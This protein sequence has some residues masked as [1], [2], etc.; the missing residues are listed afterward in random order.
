MEKHV[1]NYMKAFGYD[2]SSFI[3]CELCGAKATDI[4]HVQPRSKFGSKRK[5]EQDELENLIALCRICHEF[6]HSGKRNFKMR[7]VE[8]V[9]NRRNY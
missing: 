6:A 5:E 8:A 2:E 4:H 3:P 1:S 7:I 9:R